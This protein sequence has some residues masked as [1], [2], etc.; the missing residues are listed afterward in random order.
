M[1]ARYKIC[2]LLTSFYMKWDL[3]LF[4]IFKMFDMC[5]KTVISIRKFI[6]AHLKRWK[7]TSFQDIENKKNDILFN[8]CIIEIV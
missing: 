7:C 2:S 1:D 6:V 8:T 5:D 4:K 3:D